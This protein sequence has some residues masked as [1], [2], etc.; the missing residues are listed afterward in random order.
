LQIFAK[1]QQLNEDDEDD[2]D[3]ELVFPEFQE[4]LCNLAMHKIPNPYMPFAKVERRELA[5]RAH[6]VSDGVCYACSGSTRF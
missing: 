5:K 6:P 1:C 4:A 3:N 2:D